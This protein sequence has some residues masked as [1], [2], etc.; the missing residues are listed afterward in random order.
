MPYPRAVPEARP[1]VIHHRRRGTPG[2]PVL[3]LALVLAL[4]LTAASAA[5]TPL[6]AQD[7]ARAQ[8]DSLRR[9]VEVLRMRLDSLIR[10]RAG[11]REQQDA[12]ARL[13][14]AARARARRAGADSTERRPETFTGRQRSL[15][16]LNPEI[17]LT[18]D[19]FGAVSEEDADADNFVPREF[20]LSIVSALDPF[21]RAK[22]FFS[23]EQPGAEIE[24]FADEEG[25]EEEGAEFSVEEGYLEWVGLPG[26]LSA[27]VGR[28]FQQFGQLNRWHAHALPFQS[29][30]LPHLAFVGEESLAQDGVSI[31]WLVPVHF[32]GTYEATVEV[33]RSRNETLFGASTRP[34]VLGHFNAFWQ[35]SRTTD[36]DLGFS[37]LWGTREEDDG[38]TRRQALYGAEFSFNW[39]PP[40][41]ARYRG[42]NVRGG[43]MVHDPESAGALS[44]ETAVG[45]WS[46]AEARLGRRWIVGGRF[47]RTENPSDPGETA[48]LASPAL[49][50]W[51]SEFVRLRAEYDIL[52]Q[53][54]ETTGLF[55][56]R[57][58][59]AMGPHKHETY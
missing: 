20:E 28:F 49:T 13:R 45:F 41:R 44:G 32:G 24:V 58:T 27:K 35:L 53:G 39:V 52:G 14:E 9:E 54:G 30:S 11:A 8:V 29:R 33:T 37:G 16:A 18:G 55:T 21:S 3:R 50:F 59:F 38:L 25:E 31:H 51:Q 1:P 5:M 26:G 23:M 43:V 15:Q 56:F 4:A 19:L 57:V 2:N 36:L 47:D 40:E 34:S 12:L 22:A 48:W 7:P 10:A 6:A 17:S 46:L 42:V